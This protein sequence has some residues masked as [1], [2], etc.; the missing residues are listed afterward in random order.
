MNLRDVVDRNPMF[1]SVRD[2][3]KYLEDYDE[4]MKYEPGMK[5]QAIDTFGRDIDKSNWKP[6][7][8]HYLTHT[9]KF[10]DKYGK[11]IDWSK[12]GLA[13]DEMIELNQEVLKDVQRMDVDDHINYLDIFLFN[14]L[15]EQFKESFEA[16]L[17]RS[18]LNP[19]GW[20]I[21]Q[22]SEDNK[23]FRH[24]FCEKQDGE[25]YGDNE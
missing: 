1:D 2:V 10:L 25:N 16:A 4:M 8:E 14:G 9:L 5:A 23:V 21:E 24:S 22:L 17:S 13:Y 18:G 6:F 11:W 3:R 19:M 7:A 12:M 20:Y 15:R